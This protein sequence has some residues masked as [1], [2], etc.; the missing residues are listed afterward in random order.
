MFT[1]AANA[2]SVSSPANDIC[3]SADMVLLTPCLLTL[4]L[5]SLCLHPFTKSPAVQVQPMP[6]GAVTLTFGA[7]S[8][9]L[10]QDISAVILHLYTNDVKQEQATG[11][12]P[13]LAPV[14]EVSCPH[15]S[16]RD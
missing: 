10:A 14:T 9:P 11:K 8:D 3:M 12:A 6:S 2:N 5:Q 13:A 16:G 4:R 15:H 7:K 1:T